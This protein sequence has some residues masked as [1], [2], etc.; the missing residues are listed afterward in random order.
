LS[1]CAMRLSKWPLMLVTF[2]YFY[3]TRNDLTR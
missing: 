2:S 3:D 1:Y